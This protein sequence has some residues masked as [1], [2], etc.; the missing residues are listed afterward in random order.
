MNA[1]TLYAL[2]IIPLFLHPSIRPP[3][4]HGLSL[5]NGIPAILP[6]Y[7]FSKRHIKDRAV[8]GLS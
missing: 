7:M 3:I 8:P 4:H 5:C 2:D 1:G 6:G